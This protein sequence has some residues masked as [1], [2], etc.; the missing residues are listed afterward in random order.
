MR[1]CAIYT[2]KSTEEGLEQDFNSLDAQREACAAYVQ[3]QKGAGWRLHRARYDDGGLSGATM[4]R[5]A[6]QRLLQAVEGG[7][8]DIVVVYK[9]DRLTRSLTD[10]AKIVETFDANGVSF[11]SVT[12][13]FNTT[14]SMGRLTLNVLLSFAQFEREVT[15]ERIRDKIA[16]S[17]KK[18]LW[19]GG[20]VPLGYDVRDRKLVVNEA[21]AKLVRRLFARYLALGTV[22]RL[23]DEADRQGLVTKRRVSR[24]GKETGGRPFSRGNLYRLLANPIYV[25]RIPHRGESYP[26]QHDTIV[27]QETWTRAQD[28]LRANARTRRS[29]INAASP[30]LLT[31]LVFDETGD[32]LCPTHAN[33]KGRRYRYYISKRLMHDR[34]KHLDGWRLPAQELEALVQKLLAD[35]L[36]E[37]QRQSVNND[38]EPPAGWDGWEHFLPKGTPEER[39]ALIH[40]AIQRIDLSPTELRLTLRES[41]LVARRGES[42]DATALQPLCRLTVPIALRRRGVERKIVIQNGSN[43]RAEP[44]PVLCRL[45]SRAHNWVRQLARSEAA[46]VK[47]VA[48][49]EGFDGSDVSRILPLAFLAPDIVQAILEGRQPPELTARVLM[50]LPSLPADWQAQ[51][52]R[53][54]FPP[55]T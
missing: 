32:R 3:S 36:A 1:R 22:R 34:H 23:K 47:T 26:G 15:A 6:L 14:T 8:V 53:L 51:R 54:G 55:Q 50:R 49:R 52:R 27:D 12:Q 40:E 48:A 21:E 45:I 44:D 29:A 7:Q 31:G 35:A 10:F 38:D 46:S 25:G 28:Q 20:P 42:R 19:M 43:R 41:V 16:A 4:E 13:Q 9:V 17:K 11:V 37:S 39:R 33:K 24:S 18:G 5:P 2:R 30:S